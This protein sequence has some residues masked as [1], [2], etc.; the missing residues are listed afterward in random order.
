MLRT[1]LY[2]TTTLK[3]T[4][5][6]TLNFS[7]DVNM[8]DNRIKIKNDEETILKFKSLYKQYGY[9]LYKMSKFE[10][11]DLYAENKNFLMNSNIITFTDLNGKLMALKPDVTLSIV[12]NV[13]DS[14]HMEKVYYSENVYRVRKSGDEFREILQTGLECMGDIDAYSLGEVIMLAAKSLEIISD[15]YILDISHTG[16]VS[17]LFKDIPENEKEI[18]L[19]LVA[20]KN[21]VGIKNICEKIGLEKELIDIAY[22]LTTLYG[23]FD[24][25]IGILKE[26]SINEV[27]DKGI[28]ELESIHSMLKINKCDKNINIDFSII[29]D[30]NYYNGI[31]FQGYVS[32]IPSTILSGGRYDKLL[33]K[34][35]KDAGA[36]GF[37]IYLDM[38]DWASVN[39]DDYDTDVL[40]LYDDDTDME[41]LANAIKV[42]S[43]SGESVSVLK[44]KPVG[45]KYKRIMKINNKGVE[46][47]ETVD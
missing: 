45:G 37:A 3:Y 8:I 41:Y 32:G 15:N 4:I 11:Y 24:E 17:E 13:K 40:V 47:V 42:I 20:S 43:N 25:V 19:S 7:G 38:L 46:E 33:N 5:I 44:T 1:T 12:K 16:F 23:S 39:D 34:M 22:K 27:T 2:L 9:K 14:G 31:V 18:L 21:T 6:N 35:G 30:I 36:I 26:I 10:E 29:N 28:K